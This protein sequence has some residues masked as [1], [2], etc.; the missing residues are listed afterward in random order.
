MPRIG[1]LVPL[2]E[3]KKPLFKPQG[4]DIWIL[5][6]IESRAAELGK[7]VEHKIDQSHMPGLSREAAKVLKA[8]IKA[9]TREINALNRLLRIQKA[10]AYAEQIRK[11]RV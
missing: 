3:Y 4:D 11:P 2:A 8:E 6:R 7:T 9:D 10:N 1:K 5:Q